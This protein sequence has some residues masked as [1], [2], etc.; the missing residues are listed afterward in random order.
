MIFI[1]TNQHITSEGTACLYIDHVFKEHGLPRKVILDR[2]PQFASTF[3]TSLFHIL[4]IDAN[5]STAYHLQTDSQKERVNQEIEKYLWP[6]V[7]YQQDDWVNWLPIAQFLYND[8]IHSST[9]QS[10]F[11]MN[12][13]Q[14]P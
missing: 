1:P 4:G 10:P 12:Y 8:K 6:F 7:N 5:K 14:H 3:M 2:G 13:G 11:Y 9:G